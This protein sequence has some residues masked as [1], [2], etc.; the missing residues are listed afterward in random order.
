MAGISAFRSDDVRAAY[1]QLYDA[2]VTASTMPVTESD[3]E[4]SFG[5]TH[6]LSAGD[7][8]KPPL[9]A[10]HGIQIASTSWLPL[11]PTLAAAHRVTM[12][13]AIGQ[14]S[15]SIA[16]KPI[17]GAADIVAWLDETLRAL[18]IDRAAMVGLSMGSWMATQYALAFPDRVDRLALIGPV[19]LVSGLRLRV[20]PLFFEMAIR[21]SEAR[22]KSFLDTV[23][24]PAG[25]GRLRQDPWRLIRQQFVVGMIGFKIPLSGSGAVRPT[26]CDLGPLS[27]ARI[28]VLVIIGRD[29]LLHDG[30][31]MAARFRQR[32]P[33][34]RI[35]VID[36]ANHL[37]PVDQPEIVEKLLADFLHRRRGHPSG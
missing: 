14:V 21:P 24:T 32:L 26:R 29:E 2:A 17:T 6:V 13:D 27:S 36:D 5:R 30:P 37:I 4:T 1:C 28:P 7:P 19:G 11:L 18:G 15:K 35:E 10:M 25:R 16:T 9:V 23:V 12:I 3:I 33:E 20:L 22:L 8:S 34:A 31:K